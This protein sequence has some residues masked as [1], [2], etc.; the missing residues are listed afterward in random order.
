[1]NV[2][3]SLVSERLIHKS[4]GKERRTLGN[5]AANLYTSAGFHACAYRLSL[6]GA[7]AILTRNYDTYVSPT[8]S[9]LKAT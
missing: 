9:A 5:A 6:T 8:A 7:V 4:A 1:M 2:W 3:Q